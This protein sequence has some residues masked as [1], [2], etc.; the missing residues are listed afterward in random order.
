LTEKDEGLWSLFINNV[1][2]DTIAYQTFV[3]PDSGRAYTRVSIVAFDLTH[4][5]LHYVLGASEPLLPRL[6]N[7]AVDR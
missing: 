4:V 3:L 6:M 7:E 5:R 2:G 1:Q